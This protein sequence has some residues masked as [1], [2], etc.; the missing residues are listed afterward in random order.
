MLPE[1]GRHIS[2]GPRMKPFLSPGP[3]SCAHSERIHS[4]TK[5][6]PAQ[7]TRSN[8]ASSSLQTQPQVV[9][10]ILSLLGHLAKISVIK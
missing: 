9:L 4:P 6:S 7:V 2:P 3:C 5:P 8:V 1:S 10:V